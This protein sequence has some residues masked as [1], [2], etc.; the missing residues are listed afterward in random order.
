MRRLTAIIALLI[1]ASASACFASPSSGRSQGDDR[2]HPA[3]QLGTNKIEVNHGRPVL[4]GRSPEAM[5]Q[6]GQVWRMGAD[7]PTTLSTQASLKFGDKVIPAGTYILQAKLVEPQ[8]WHLQVNSEGGS[9]IAEVPMTLQK[10]DKS[11]EYLTITLDKKDEGGRLTLQWGT[12]ALAADFQPAAMT[13]SAE[14]GDKWNELSAFHDVMSATF[15]PMQ[16]GDFKPIRDRAAEMA[17]KGKQWADSKPPK[18]YDKP[19]IKTNVAKL[20]QESKALATLVA[21]KASD[22]Q[23]KESLST[24]H[25]RFHEIIGLCRDAKKQST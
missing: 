5:I 2:G 14:D 23:I 20:A 1:F 17:A 22:A 10:L 7:D 13:A 11:V 15:H 19:E 4:R 24:L 18:L 6:P 25:D 21:K 8:K 12:L 3:L 16:E 9:P